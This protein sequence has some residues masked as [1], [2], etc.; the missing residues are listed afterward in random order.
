MRSQTAHHKK[1]YSSGG[2]GRGRGSSRDRYLCLAASCW[3]C[4]GGPLFYHLAQHGKGQGSVIEDG[5][6]EVA[7]VVGGSKPGS[8][9]VAEAQDLAL[10]D[11]VT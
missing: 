6:V 1:F 11:E 10:P 4:G 5:G 7:D 9:I 2:R 3:C 8:G